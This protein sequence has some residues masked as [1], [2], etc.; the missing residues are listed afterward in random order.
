MKLEHYS[1]TLKELENNL[2]TQSKNYGSTIAMI[3]AEK[4]IIPP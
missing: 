4:G 3:L 1:M 2:T